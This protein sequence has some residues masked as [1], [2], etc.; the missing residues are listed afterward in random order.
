MDCKDDI[1][2]KDPHDE[3]CDRFDS[4]KYPKCIKPK[5]NECRVS[6]LNWAKCKNWPDKKCEENTIIWP[7]CNKKYNPTDDK[8]D[9]NEDEE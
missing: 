6:S 3:G 8:I 4:Q 1:I 7:G 5:I 2:S 9:E